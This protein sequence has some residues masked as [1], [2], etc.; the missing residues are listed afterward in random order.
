[1]TAERLAVYARAWNVDVEGALETPTS[2]I[3]YGRRAHEGVV[4]KLVKMPGDEWNAGEV[5]AAFQ[6]RGIVRVY[7]HAPGAMMLER[8]TP[9]DSLVSL[10]LNGRDDEATAVIADIIAAMSPLAPP[11]GVPTIDDLGLAF[12]R[13]HT[14]NA[15]LVAQAADVYGR[16]AQTQTGARLLHGDLHHS[17]VLFDTHRGWTAI[18]PKGV[19]G[20]LEFEIGAALRNPIER[21]DLWFKPEIIDRRIRIF[22]ERL[23][24]DARR[25]L[26]WAFAQ[27]VLSAIWEIEDGFVGAEPRSLAL[28]HATRPLLG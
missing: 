18:D 24:L 26:E 17:N 21:P 23:R 15:D 27:A 10:S 4:I 22:A 14:L 1:M 7:E 2:I 5:L 12:S 20:E 28:A 16:L 19:V 13:P 8:L 6:G 11:A 3:A 9:G 25:I